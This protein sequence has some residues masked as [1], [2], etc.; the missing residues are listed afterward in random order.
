MLQA[1]NNMSVCLLYL[2]RLKDSVL[3]LEEALQKCPTLA[4]HES[5]L[6][7]LCTLYE[8]QSSF[9]S[10]PKLKLLSLVNQYKG[11]GINLGCLKLQM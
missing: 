10:Q 2:G 1:I 3:L 8:L 4:L 5:L 6:L 11:D 7:N 9:C